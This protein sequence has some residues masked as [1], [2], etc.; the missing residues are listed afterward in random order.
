M[1]YTLTLTTAI[2]MQPKPS[3]PT[4]VTVLGILAILAGLGGLIGG[5]ALLGLSGVVASTYPGGAA[6][7]AVIGAVLLIIGILELVYGIGFFGGK[8]WAWTLAMIGSVLNI[9]FGIVSLAFGSTGSIFGLIISIIIL[10]YLT[11]PH[12]KAYFGK[13]PS[14]MGPSSMP[15]GGM[16]SMPGSMGSSPTMGSIGMTCKNCGASIP[17]GATRC[18]SC[19]AS[20]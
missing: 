13:G 14:M 20:I 18:P 7:A 5:A 10:Y 15:P 4:G 3:R 2:F 11:R 1:L 6:V 12:V 19:G 16:G 9:V 17:A 8:G